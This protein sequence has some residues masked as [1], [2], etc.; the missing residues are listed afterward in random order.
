MKLFSY[1]SKFI[2]FMNTLVD[3]VVI[4]FLWIIGCIPIITIGTSTIAAYTLL[5]KIVD[6]AEGKIFREFWKAYKDNFKHGTILTFIFAAAVY[7][8]WIDF[9]LFDAV[10][11]NPIIFTIIGFILVFLIVIYGIYIF[12]LEARYENRLSVAMSNAWRIGVRFFLRT[13]AIVCIVGFEVWLFYG[14]NDIL[15]VIGLLIGPMCIMLTI[16]GIVMPI[17]RTL[18]KEAETPDGEENGT[19]LETYSPDYDDD[20]QESSSHDYSYENDD[21][22][23]Y[24]APVIV[25]AGDTKNNE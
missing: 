15:F 11:G 21:D 10:E 3:I 4:N 16:S 8:V 7:S 13:L 24:D 1:D 14:I 23:D 19:R 20:I 12:P 9:Q 25:E 6:N 18:E 5:L 22:I 2:E 17:F